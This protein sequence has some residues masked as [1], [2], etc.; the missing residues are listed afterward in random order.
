MIYTKSNKHGDLFCRLIACEKP[1]TRKEE[2]ERHVSRGKYTDSTSQGT[3][4]REKKEKTPA[5]IWWRKLP[6]SFLYFP[7]VPQITVI[8]TKAP[9][10][11]SSEVRD[12]HQ[13]R[14]SWYMSAWLFGSPTCLLPG[15]RR[16]SISLGGGCLPPWKLGTFREVPFLLHYLV[17]VP[18]AH[19][20]PP[21]P[22]LRHHSCRPKHTTALGT[23]MH[24]HKAVGLRSL[25][26]QC[27]GHF[28]YEVK[29]NNNNPNTNPSLTLAMYETLF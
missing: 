27:S 9:S 12:S 16:L 25:K 24:L 17:T 4:H 26:I 5:D 8:T 2:S 10:S 6:A 13:T 18:S 28:D 11:V 14:K 23:W 20:H 3:W 22:W 21:V 19:A 7:P 15:P 29:D 1:L